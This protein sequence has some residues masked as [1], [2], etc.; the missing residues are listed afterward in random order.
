MVKVQDIAAERSLQRLEELSTLNAIGNI[1]NAEGDFSVAIEQALTRLVNLLNLQAGWVFLTRVSQGDSHQGSFR[2][3]AMTGLPPALSRDNNAP[4]CSGSCDCQWR[5]KQGKLDKGVNIVHCSRLE[6]ATEDKE[7]LE[8]HASMPLLGQSGPVGILNLAATGRER[9]DADT[10]AF[11]TTV[12][13]QLGTAFE[14]S[15]LQAEREQ[16]ARHAA[17]LEE[18]QRLATEMHDSVAQLLFGAELSLKV[19][20]EGRGEQR[21]R[22]LTR[23]AELVSSAL[24]ELRGLVEV[25][26]PADLSQGLASALVRLAQRTQETGVSVHLETHSIELPERHAE[27]LYRVAQEA[28]HNALRHANAQNIW[29]RLEKLGRE[30]RLSVED[31]GRGLAEE[32][33]HGLGLRSMK[34]RVESLEGRLELTSHPGFNRGLRLEVILPHG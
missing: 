34:T 21:E 16:G 32:V 5:F 26:R 15:K 11:L 19:A 27:A 1:L 13:Q 24:G 3:A 18:R 9:F 10:L 28:L 23:G 20:Q 31:D 7:G 25:L 33:E 6:A 22:S 17:T 30:V 29:M 14:R 12:G 8:I 4:L 2:V